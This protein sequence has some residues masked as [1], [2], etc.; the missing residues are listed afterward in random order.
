M[1]LPQDLSQLL[2]VAVRDLLWYKSNVSGF[3]SDCD[4]PPLAI[5]TAKADDPNPPTIRLISA[6]LEELYLRGDDGFKVVQVMVTKLYYWNDLHTVAVE[7]KEKAIASLKAFREGVDRFKAQQ[8]YLREQENKV[9]YE[10]VAKK[11]VKAVD[12]AKLQKFRDEF[13]SIH[14]LE[15]RQERGRRFQDLMNDV[16]D[17]HADESKGAFERSGEQIDGLFKLD[18]HWYLVEARWKRKKA[19]A[20]DISVLRDRAK[21]AYG[22]DTKALFISFEGFSQDCLQNLSGRDD[23]RVVLMDGF[24]F[25][26]VLDAKIAFETLISEK[27]VALIKERRPF[28]SAA[29]ILAKS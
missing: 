26:C 17:H 1:R 7:R 22:G 6:V 25:R 14:R 24:D 3:L 21:A 8:E 11:D 12:H 23:E 27:Q 16:F 9:H 10:R 18:S 4:V 20:A 15:N 5:K 2:A 13:D 29:E 19:K 28:V